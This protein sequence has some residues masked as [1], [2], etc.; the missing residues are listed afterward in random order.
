MAIQLSSQP[1]TE[2]NK[3]LWVSILLYL[4]LALFLAS[5]SSYFVF[6]YYIKKQTKT[7]SEI[8][9]EMKQKGTNEEKKREEILLTKQ[10]KIKDFSKL[11][12]E[13]QFVSGF[14]TNFES[15]WCHPRV[16]FSRINLNVPDLT[17]ALSGQTD[18]FET[19]GQQVLVLRNNKFI[20]GIDLSNIQMNDVGRIDF[21][22]SIIF[23]EQV[24]SYDFSKVT[25]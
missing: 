23:D 4:S 3:A 18:N 20:K 12:D 16:W 15:Q 17:A 8:K 6:D 24:L 19:L 7:I 10:D 25:E 14:F 2:T 13:H 1:K 5:V 9:A 11:L 22:L 21:N